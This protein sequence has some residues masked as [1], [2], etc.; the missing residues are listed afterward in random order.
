MMNLRTIDLAGTDY[1]AQVT[2]LRRPRILIQAARHGLTDYR[3]ERDLGRLLGTATGRGPERS[4]PR[5]LAEESR[6]DDLRRAKD[7]TY[8]I[9]RHVRVLVALLGELQML[10]R[11]VPQLFVVP[12]VAPVAR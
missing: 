3:R 12:K 5:L 2:A 10:P 1:W 9:R 4:M 7:A 6:L 11:P 8:D